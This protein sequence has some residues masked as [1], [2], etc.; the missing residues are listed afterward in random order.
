MDKLLKLKDTNLKAL[1]EVVRYTKLGDNILI[2]PVRLREEEQEYQRRNQDSI[3]SRLQLFKPTIELDPLHFKIK[4]KP[5]YVL[6]E[7]RE[8]TEEKPPKNEDSA[9]ILRAHKKRESI[10]M[11]EIFN[12]GTYVQT[13]DKDK[14]SRARFKSMDEFTV[15]IN[16]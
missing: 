11:Q 9:Q 5:S 2:E 13:A 7:K 1:N 12:K 8:V 3:I 16:S 4:E 15:K 10:L 6:R 14:S